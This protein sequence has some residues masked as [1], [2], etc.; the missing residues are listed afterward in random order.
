MG[1]YQHR[2]TA[3]QKLVVVGE[4][5]YLVLAFNRSVSGEKTDNFFYVKPVYTEELHQNQEPTN[6]PNCLVLQCCSFYHTTMR[7][8]PLHC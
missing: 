2:S 4:H 1:I 3:E 7:L 8:N 5:T 6:Y